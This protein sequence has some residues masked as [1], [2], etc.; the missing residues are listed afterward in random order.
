MNDEQQPQHHHHHHSPRRSCPHCGHQTRIDG[1]LCSACHWAHHWNTA[2]PV[3][4]IKYLQTHYSRRSLIIMFILAA[5]GQLLLLLSNEELQ[6]YLDFT[7]Q[8]RV[9]GHL[10]KTLGE[11]L[12]MQQLLHGLR[13][14]LHSMQMAC[15]ITMILLLAYHVLAAVLLLMNAYI[16]WP[17]LITTVSTATGLLLVLG[18]LAAIMF[19]FYIYNCYNGMLG[20]T[21][22][23]MSLAAMTHLL[24]NLVVHAAGRDL[25][26]DLAVGIVTIT[27]FYVLQS[28]FL[29]HRRYKAATI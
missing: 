29:D 21:G 11:T 5:V 8:L 18:E 20:A 27:Y 22:I 1:E 10:M 12:L 9:T 19:G 7:T 24:L 26:A 16:D 23:L 17:H 2:S 28:R 3:T 14:E 6:P 15:R 13:F 4:H 25:A